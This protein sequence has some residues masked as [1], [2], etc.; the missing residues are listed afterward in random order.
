MK[1]DPNLDGITHINI[2]SKGRM[3]LGRHMSNFTHQTFEMEGKIFH[4]VEAYWYW[5]LLSD[6]PD[7]DS[8][9]ELY[10]F[11]AKQEGRKLIA[12]D[13]PDRKDIPEFR[14]KIATAIIKRV[15][16]DKWLRDELTNSTLPFVHYYD[17]QGKIVEPNDN[18]GICSIWESVRRYLHTI[19]QSS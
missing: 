5:L 13:W 7:K 8:L 18:V 19:N 1:F 15:K 11:K 6:H 9:C 10:G 14:T 17:Y 3:P 2:Y 4:S 12:K 16:K